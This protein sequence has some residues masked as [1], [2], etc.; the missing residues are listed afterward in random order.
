MTRPNAPAVASRNVRPRDSRP[1]PKSR[2]TTAYSGEVAIPPPIGFSAAQNEFGPV[3]R[4]G[5]RP[6]K[7]RVGFHI[8]L[9]ADDLTCHQLGEYWIQPRP[10]PCNRL[11]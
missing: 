6:S 11:G 8:T 5:G 4:S 2:G 1:D 3:D 9:V 7:L 10:P